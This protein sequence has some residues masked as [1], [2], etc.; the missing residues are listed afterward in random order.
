MPVKKK[1]MV[2]YYFPGAAIIKYH[3]L[4]GLN[5]KNLLSYTSGS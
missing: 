5:N 1:N 4:G 2:Y 3:K